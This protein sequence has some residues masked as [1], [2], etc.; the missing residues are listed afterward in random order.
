MYSRKKCEELIEQG[1]IIDDVNT[2][3]IDEESS[4]EKGARVRPNTIIEKSRISG[5]AVIGPNSRVENSKI[6]GASSMIL[7]A[8]QILH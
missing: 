5:R 3:Y 1:V 6:T 2:T 4:I 7:T 8:V